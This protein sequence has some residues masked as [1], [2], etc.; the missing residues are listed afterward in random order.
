MT[1]SRSTYISRDE[2]ISSL[3]TTEHYCIIYMYHVFFIHSS[4]DGHLGSNSPVER[5]WA[6]ASEDPGFRVWWA[7]GEKTKQTL[8]MVTAEHVSS[9]FISSGPRSSFCSVI[10]PRCDLRHIPSHLGAVSSINRAEGINLFRCL[11]VGILLVTLSCRHA[12]SGR[13]E[14]CR[15]SKLSLGIKS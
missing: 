6:L 3:F 12:G 7:L 9:T 14:F 4:V 8:H 5:V 2:Q 13:E 10:A 11:W 15:V 1:L